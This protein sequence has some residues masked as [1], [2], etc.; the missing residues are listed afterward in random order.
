MADLSR[1]PIIF[2]TDHGI[3]HNPEHVID[4]REHSYASAAKLAIDNFSKYTTQTLLYIVNEDTVVDFSC[5]AVRNNIDSLD[6]HSCFVFTSEE[7]FESLTSMFKEPEDSQELEDSEEPE[8]PEEPEYEVKCYKF[9]LQE[10]GA[11]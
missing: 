11:S 5:S 3:F 2:A 1:Y 10:S 6:V 7:T 8:A 4:V 9:F